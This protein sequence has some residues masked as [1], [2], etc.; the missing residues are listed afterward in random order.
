MAFNIRSRSGWFRVWVLLSLLWGAFVVTTTIK[1]M[2]TEASLEAQLQ[3]D[4]AGIKRD[5]ERK[6]TQFDKTL[7]ERD[8]VPLPRALTLVEAAYRESQLRK[9]HAK[10]LSSLGA[11]RSNMT[12][13]GVL[14]W[15]VPSLVV[16]AL[17][18][19][20]VL[21]FSWIFRGFTQR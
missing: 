16:Y 7:F 14:L 8:G 17:A 15:I 19:L 2:P 6:P 11:E 18:W 9:E 1:Q 4:L 10:A 12:R 20:L 5:L 13:E 3:R 21:V